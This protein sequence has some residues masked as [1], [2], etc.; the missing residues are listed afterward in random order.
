MQTKVKKRYVL[1]RTN[2]E[3]NGD[4][5]SFHVN[6]YF[7]CVTAIQRPNRQTWIVEVR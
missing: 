1:G 5:T 3:P 2:Q 6:P 4:T 7:G